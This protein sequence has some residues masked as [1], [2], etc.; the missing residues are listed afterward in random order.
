MKPLFNTWFEQG[1][2]LP[3]S[4]ITNNKN[5]AGNAGNKDRQESCLSDKRRYPMHAISGPI[6]V[7]TSF[8]S[9]NG[10]IKPTAA[11]DRQSFERRAAGVRKQNGT[12]DASSEDGILH[13]VDPMTF[14][15]YTTVKGGAGSTKESQWQGTEIMQQVA[16]EDRV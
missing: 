11:T 15:S 13:A 2:T 10:R 14:G 3:W 8:G 16:V 1:L 12:E 7:D 5:N 6:V 4:R 9:S